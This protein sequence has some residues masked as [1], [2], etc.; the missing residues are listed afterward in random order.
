M[1][2]ERRPEESKQIGVVGLNRRE[3][4]FSEN[5]GFILNN[6]VLSNEEPE[7]LFSISLEFQRFMKQDLRFSESF[8]NSVVLSILWIPFSSQIS[9]KMPQ[10]TCGSS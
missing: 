2:S 4:I 9:L 6:F 3:K 7:F 10:C 1:N 8:S 5:T